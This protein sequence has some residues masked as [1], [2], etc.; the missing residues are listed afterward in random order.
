M[1][2][3]DKYVYV[4]KKLMLIADEDIVDLFWIQNLDEKG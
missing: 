1:K 4:K 2:R 3:W